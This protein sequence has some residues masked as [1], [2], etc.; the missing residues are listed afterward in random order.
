ML[1]RWGLV[2]RQAQADSAII[3]AA[4][5]LITMS[6]RRIV[7]AP[8]VRLCTKTSRLPMDYFETSASTRFAKSM[9]ESCHPR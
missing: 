8:R 4:A 7:T 1:H 9:S 2:G 6:C 5:M 3:V